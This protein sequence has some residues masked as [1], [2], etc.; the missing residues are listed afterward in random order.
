M[1]PSYGQPLLI[2]PSAHIDGGVFRPIARPSA[3]E[4]QTFE[5]KGAA[6]RLAIAVAS[7]FVEA[8]ALSA[9]TKVFQGVSPSIPVWLLPKSPDFS[10]V[11]PSA[12]VVE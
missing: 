4:T 2:D 10:G 12:N 9:A 5:D 3:V 6:G 1:I 11:Q 8:S 7:S